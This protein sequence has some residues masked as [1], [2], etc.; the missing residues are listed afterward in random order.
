M[1]RITEAQLASQPA[2]TVAA[3]AE[4]PVPAPVL[5][6]ELELELELEVGVGAGVG[7]GVG[8]EWVGRREKRR[9]L[10]PTS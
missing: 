9:E 2:G 3:V 6:L 1:F 8:V 5:G 10:S 7:I 4:L